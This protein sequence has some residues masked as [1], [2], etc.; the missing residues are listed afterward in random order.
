MRRPL[1]RHALIIGAAAYPSDPLVNSAEDARRIAGPLEQRG[2]TVTL[3]INP[4]RDALGD[5]LTA[6]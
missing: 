2:F 5:A 6:F 1:N 3:V 4:D